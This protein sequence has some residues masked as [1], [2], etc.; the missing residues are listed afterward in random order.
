MMKIALK[1]P[2]NFER[3]HPKFFKVGFETLYRL[4]VYIV[5][6]FSRLLK[7]ILRLI[8]FGRTNIL[9]TDLFFLIFRMNFSRFFEWI[10]NKQSQKTRKYK[11]YFYT[12]LFCM[13]HFFL[14][15][16]LFKRQN[17]RTIL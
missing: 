9:G 4:F 3:N 12:H 11:E 14:F 6:Q 1:R 15:I 13:E 10:F 7:P 8:Y 16:S 5:Q 2:Y 17:T